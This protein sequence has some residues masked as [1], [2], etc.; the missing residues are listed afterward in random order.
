MAQ[1]KF[2]PPSRRSWPRAS[3]ASSRT[4]SACCRRRPSWARTC[5]YNLL[6]AVADL[7][8]TA[9]RHGL[10]ALQAA[11]FVYETSLFPDLEYTFKHALTHEVAYN[12]VLNERRKALHGRIVAALETLYAG[13]LTEQVERLAHHALRGELWDK[14]YAYY[15][16]AGEKALGR[17]ANREALAAFEQ[18]LAALARQPKTPETMRQAIDLRIFL[19]LPLI[20]LTEHRRLLT[21]MKEAESLVREIDDPSR[22][23]QVLAYLCEAHTIVGE[24]R[25][26]ID[27]GQRAVQLAD[28]L[29][30]T[31]L[32]VLSRLILGIASAQ[33]G[34]YRAA[35]PLLRASADAARSAADLDECCEICQRHRSRRRYTPPMPTYGPN[36]TR[37]FAWPSWEI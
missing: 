13:R 2:L 8:D 28:R 21:I 34:A 14:A 29:G 33:Q 20:A 16:Q 9:L 30:R 1:S 17:S 25:V 35:L 19:E 12:G 36:A 10:D 32:I 23:C 37:H 22:E 15:R 24:W 3:I 6:Q 31:R 27:Y 5:A 11:E 18:A 4:T 26:G 7:P